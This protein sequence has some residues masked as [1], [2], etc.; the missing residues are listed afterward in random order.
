MLSQGDLNDLQ[1][2]LNLSKG[3]SELLG[4]RLQQ[5]SLLEQGV[6]ITAVRNRSANLAECFDVKENLCYCK[7]ITQLFSVMNQPFI[8]DEWRLFIDGSKTSI[9]AV[10]LHNGNIKPSIPVAFAIL[11]FGRKFIK[12]DHLKYL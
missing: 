11:Q 9:K 7:N 5:W 1:R 3:M 10:L 2:D 4:S 6:H 12:M 8:P